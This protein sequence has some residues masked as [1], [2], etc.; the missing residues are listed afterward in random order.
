MLLHHP[1][2]NHRA[3]HA[4][5]YFHLL[6][7]NSWVQMPTPLLWRGERRL[8]ILQKALTRISSPGH[9]VYTRA[10]HSMRR[11][12]HKSTLYSATEGT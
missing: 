1:R 8:A 12:K 2:L 10:V 7:T 11:C 6:G 4:A 3:V 5:H 9:P